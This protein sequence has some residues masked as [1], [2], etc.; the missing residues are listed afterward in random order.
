MSLV[1]NTHDVILATFKTCFKMLIA[2]SNGAI[3]P[4]LSFSGGV[5]SGAFYM[6]R[7]ISCGHV[8]QPLC[9]CLLHLYMWLTVS[10]I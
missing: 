8:H 4:F 6:F 2:T 1:R 9:S 5:Q 7:D 10:V 3:R